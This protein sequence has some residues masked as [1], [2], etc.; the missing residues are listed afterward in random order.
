MHLLKKSK[1]LFNLAMTIDE[2]RWENLLELI[3]KASLAAFAQQYA[4]NESHLSQLKNRTRNIGK[5]FARQLENKMGIP[6]GWMDATHDGGQE[7]AEGLPL[8]VAD[9]RKLA[10]LALFDAL[11]KSAQDEVISDLA[12]KK[13]YFEQIL[14][15]MNERQ[16]KKA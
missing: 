5:G 9:P 3:G 14:Q 7:A 4:L 16:L 6:K 10:L 13:Q 2:I 12:A 8:T 1:L 11:P 15:E